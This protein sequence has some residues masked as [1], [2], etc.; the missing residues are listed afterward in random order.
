MKATR[1]INVM[2]MCMYS[3]DVIY[4]DCVIMRK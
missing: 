3:T 2:C 1:Y 4:Q